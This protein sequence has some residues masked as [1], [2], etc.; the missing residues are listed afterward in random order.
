LW[1][2]QELINKAIEFDNAPAA[3]T[4]STSTI[5]TPKRRPVLVLLDGYALDVTNY[6]QHH[7]GG[8]AYLREYAIPL[9]AT[10]A[11]DGLKDAS[12]A[13]NGGMNNHGT[14]ARTKMK[15]LRIAKIID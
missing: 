5:A 11:T 1:T 8:V 9:R 10:A 7:P 12:N 3:S 14:A 6:V 13:F 15:S 4:T 2:R